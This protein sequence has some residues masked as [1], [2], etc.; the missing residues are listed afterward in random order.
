MEE[1][2]EDHEEVLEKPKAGSSSGSF[3]VVP[4]LTAQCCAFLQMKS[5][6]ELGRELGREKLMGGEA[7]A[8]TEASSAGKI[9]RKS[10]GGRQKSW[11][12]VMAGRDY[13]DSKRLRKAASDGSYEDLLQEIRRG[14]DVTKADSKGRTA[15]HF[16]ATR[17]DTNM[18]KV[19]VSYGAS[20]H[21]YIL[22]STLFNTVKVL[23]SYGASEHTYILISTL[24]N[25]VK[26]LVSYGASE[27][28]Y[29]LIST[30]FNTV[31]VLVSYGAS[32][33]QRDC[34]GNTPLHLACCTHHVGVVTALL[35]SGTDVN[36]T[37][38]KGVTPLHLAL[39]RLRM[40][41]GKESKEEGGGGS[42]RGG[43]GGNGAPSFRKKE[44]MHI[45]EMIKEYL[46]VSKSSSQ[47]E[48]VEL[49]R[50]AGQLS[51]SETPQQ[52][53]EVQ[54]LLESFTSLSL[55]KRQETAS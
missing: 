27:H 35:K 38:T 51:I 41:G 19:L 14:V 50:L 25:T 47:N 48:T 52:V 21:T 3:G 15:L 4:S 55:Q 17:G 39:S 26:V 1:D 8:G 6:E 34:N 22:I 12:D 24:F 20:E 2:D 32:V 33:N 28:T 10:G 36:A 29:I 42:E 53:D 31:K 23:V 30:L 16:A 18:V 43:E 44:I 45:V 13:L 7:A 54:G 5:F 40:L 49:E 11:V 9:R 37:D 46:H